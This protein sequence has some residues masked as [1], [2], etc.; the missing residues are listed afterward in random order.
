MHT[1]HPY[2]RKRGFSLVEL[3]VVIAVIGIIA[4]IAIANLSNTD[5][6]SRT[7]SAKSQ[8]QRIAA[9][10]CCGQAAGAP[11]FASVNSVDSAI[12]AVATGSFGAGINKTS[13]F[14]LPGVSATMDQGRPV[15]HQARHYLRWE[16]GLLAYDPSGEGGSSSGNQYAD[17]DQWYA[18]RNAAFGAWW[19]ANP[20]GQGGRDYVHAWHIANPPPGSGGVLI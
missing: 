15:Q 16:G 11:G 10:F 7:V 9:T 18:A 4:C 17:W 5:S 3:L 6:N 13:Y 1:H 8:A 12:N 19:Q 14:Q 2:R 20:G